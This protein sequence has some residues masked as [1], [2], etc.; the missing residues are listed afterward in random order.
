MAACLEQSHRHSVLF[1]AR[2]AEPTQSH[3]RDRERSQKPQP[4]LSLVVISERVSAGRAGF[5]PSNAVWAGPVSALRS[6]PLSAYA[7]DGNPAT[8]SKA[9]AVQWVWEILRLK[10]GEFIR[11]RYRRRRF[12]TSWQE[13]RRTGDI[14]WP[15]SENARID[16]CPYASIPRNHKARLVVLWLLGATEFRVS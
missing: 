7:A 8:C 10:R 11:T 12:S 14:H 3:H 2:S 15:I 5:D 6:L 16:H 4:I 9:H 1:S 13:I